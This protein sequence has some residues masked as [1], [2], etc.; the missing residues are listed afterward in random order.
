MHVTHAQPC[1]SPPHIHTQHVSLVLVP[2]CV[3][4]HKCNQRQQQAHTQPPSPAGVA[5]YQCLKLNARCLTLQRIRQGQRVSTALQLT[6]PGG[7][8]QG[9]SRTCDHGEGGCVW[10]GGEGG[11]GV[12]VCVEDRGC[13]HT[14]AGC[15]APLGSK[16][17]RPAIRQ[18]L[19]LSTLRCL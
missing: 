17:A 12:W 16:P 8:G 18:F 6:R 10:G 15:T 13:A 11:A 9:A 5:G 2:I 1:L 7:D 19:F 14:G 3:N 4:T